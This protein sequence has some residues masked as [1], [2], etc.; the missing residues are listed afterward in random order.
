[1]ADKFNGPQRSGWNLFSPDWKALVVVDP[2]YPLDYYAPL[3]RPINHPH[4]RST[5]LLLERKKSQP[6]FRLL[7]SF[8]ASQIFGKER[9]KTMFNTN[10]KKVQ[11]QKSDW[12]RVF[13]W[14]HFMQ[15]WSG[16][17]KQLLIYELWWH[18]SSTELIVVTTPTVMTSCK[19]HQYD[20]HCSS[21]ALTTVITD[22]TAVQWRS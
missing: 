18:W 6:C 5:A 2:F 14:E 9:M 10:C 8:L 15:L 16:F 19:R 12:L 11:E 13:V 3:P 20:E 21:P 4:N 7:I 22:G 17:W 1:M